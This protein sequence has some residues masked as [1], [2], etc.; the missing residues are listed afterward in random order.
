MADVRTGADPGPLF[1]RTAQAAVADRLRSEILAGALEPGQRLRQAAL[2][3]RM[4]T[5]TTP[6]REA[7][8]QL[9]AE[10]LVDMDPHRGVIVH[11]PTEEELEEIYEILG[12]LEPLSIRKTVAE[13]SDEEVHRAEA[14]LIEMENAADPT[15][16]IDLN[17][18]FHLFLA[19]C[20][21][22]P[23]L[24]D[25]VANLRNRSALYLAIAVREWP[26]QTQVGNRHHRELLDACRRRDREQAVRIV[27]EHHESTVQVGHRYLEGRARRHQEEG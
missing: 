19:A 12:L 17:R 2:A 8:R 20:S 23:E 1:P 7:M 22:S 14:Y 6:V 11:E 27:R 15:R 3:E 18:D 26:E 16:W 24:T 5:S 25:L 10:G 9:A 13:I 4:R 21:R